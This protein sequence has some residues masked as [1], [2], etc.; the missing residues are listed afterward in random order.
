M[1]L[2]LFTIGAAI[3]FIAGAAFARKRTEDKVSKEYEKEI[4]ELQRIHKE[5]EKDA[6]KKAKD[7][8]V[9]EDKK[10][11]EDISKKNGYSPSSW[12]SEETEDDE[13]CYVISKAEFGLLDYEIRTI[14]IF[15]D[16]TIEDSLGETVEDLYAMIGIDIEELFDS[17]DQSSAYTINHDSETY[18]EIIR[19]V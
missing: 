11:A 10:T 17:E 14:E 13:S 7:E 12:S 8:I 3:G 16:G 4:E 5:K 9:A 18:F 6:V 2:R 1:G 19:E 15:D